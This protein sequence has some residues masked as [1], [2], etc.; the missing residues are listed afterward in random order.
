MVMESG[1]RGV[2][3]TQAPDVLGQQLVVLDAALFQAVENNDHDT[4]K[5]VAQRL[6]DVREEIHRISGD[7]PGQY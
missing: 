3:E 6:A 7:A 5:A 2:E 4:V 1:R